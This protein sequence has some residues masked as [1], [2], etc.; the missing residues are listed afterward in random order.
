[1]QTLSKCRKKVFSSFYCI[2]L[3]NYCTQRIVYGM[4][5]PLSLGFISAVHFLTGKR[6]WSFSKDHLLCTNGLLQCQ[7]S[8]M[9]TL[10]CRFCIVTVCNFWWFYLYMREGSLSIFLVCGRSFHMQ[11]ISMVMSWIWL[12]VCRNHKSLSSGECFH[13]CEYQMAEKIKISLVS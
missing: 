11:S 7:S 9:L 5:V 3:S 6:D 10:L 1:M 12:C 13:H 4:Q 2:N 8:G